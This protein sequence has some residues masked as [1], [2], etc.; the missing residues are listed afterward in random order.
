MTIVFW[1]TSL[2]F[3]E[4]RPTDLQQTLLLWAISTLVFLGM[5]TLGFIL[6]RNLVKL[7]AERRADH[8]GSKI[9]TRLVAGALGLTILPTAF[10]FFF[11]FNVLNRTLDKWFSQPMEQVQRTSFAISQRLKESARDKAERLA[12]WI[13]SLPEVATAAARGSGLPAL[14]AALE[15]FARRQDLE[16]VAVGAEG[17]A[18]PWAQ[19][20]AGRSLSQLWG[21]TVE[22]RRPGSAGGS[23]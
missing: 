13:A 18:A 11:A 8:V 19:Y 10:L 14:P 3:G 17:T 23:L 15:A 2:S 4:F 22:L 16:Y 21:A 20:T 1:Q 9:K 7:Y 5:V 12:E 6:F